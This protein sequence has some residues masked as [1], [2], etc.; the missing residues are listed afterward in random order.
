MASKHATPPEAC[1]E[2]EGEALCPTDPVRTPVDRLGAI[3][4]DPERVRIVTIDVAES[5]HRQDRPL[6]RRVSYVAP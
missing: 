6:A 4:M 3:C 1:R 5:V 2:V